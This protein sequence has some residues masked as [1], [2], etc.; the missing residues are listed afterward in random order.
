MSDLAALRTPLHA[1][2]IEEKA[3]L[4]PFAGWD[5]PVQYAGILEESRAVR[6]AVGLFDISHMGRVIVS[7]AGACAFLDKLTSNDVGGLAPSR[8]HYS[9]L[10]NPNGGIVDDIIVYRQAEERFLVVI[11]AA[12]AQKDLA[13]MRE[14]LPAGVTIEDR[15][16]ATAMIAVQGPAAPLAVDGLAEADVI[17]I[18]RFAYVE[19]K[20]AGANATICRTGYTGE[21]GFEL[22]VDADRAAD[23]WRALRTAGAAPCGLGARDALR[24]EAGYP[25]YGHE[26][27]D[28]TTPVE[29]GLMWVVKAAKG[30]FIGRDAILAT[31]ERGAGRKLV[32]FTLAD[33]A[34]PRAEYTL[35]TGDEQVGTVT[36]GVFSPTLSRGLGMAYVNDPHHKTGTML[37]L[38]IRDK[39][40]A[41]T[42]VPKK[43]LLAK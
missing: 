22:I 38:A 6:S 26:I 12:N 28:T 2:H 9:L 29:A 4:V 21:D 42:I 14:H 15:T 25:L 32:G 19:G 43:D 36:S 1:V 7:G 34:V 41:A 30:D 5:M 24:I 16:M 11:N 3:R 18:G 39:R 17:G 20:V 31:K 27:D 33:R 13:W 23:V 35:W 37:D 8:A 10:T 40:F